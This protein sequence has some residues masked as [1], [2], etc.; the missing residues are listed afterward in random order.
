MNDI[1]RQKNESM[2]QA[3]IHA[4]RGEIEKSIENLTHVEELESYQD[5]IKFIANTWLAKN[6][7]ERN[8][9]LVFAPTNKNR[10]D[11]CDVKKFLCT[12][13][14]RSSRYEADYR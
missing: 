10:E 3:V 6:I 8:Q 12:N 11:I 4:T 7:D 2:R 13:L 9:T 14:T 5:R 1:A